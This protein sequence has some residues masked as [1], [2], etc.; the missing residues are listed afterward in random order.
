MRLPFLRSKDPAAERGI[1]SPAGDDSTAV[2]QARTRACRRLSGAVVLLLAGVIGFPLLFE[3]QPRPL[4]VDTPI[5]VRPA[6]AA[7]PAARPRTLPAADAGLERA[8]PPVPAS[9]A[10]KPTN[11]AVPAREVPVAPVAAA[12]SAMKAAAA[13]SAAPAAPS[14]ATAAASPP[15]AAGPEVPARSAEAPAAAEKRPAAGATSADEGARARAL[16]EGSTASAASAAA[17]PRFV[18]Q[19]GAY[20]DAETLRRARQ[21]VER[22][23]MKTYTQVIETDA[24]KRTRVRIGPFASQ[25]EADAAAARLKGVGLPASIL[26]L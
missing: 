14:T 9:A 20:T 16:L 26:A 6:P 24:G 22:L 3:T 13:A 2:E 18:V 17:V 21:A 11:E 5:E 4:P 25:A 19:A 12:A 1:P 10:A 15:P 7:A 23:G 8:P